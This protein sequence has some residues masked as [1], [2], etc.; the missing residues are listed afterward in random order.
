MPAKLLNQLTKGTSMSKISCRD[1]PIDVIKQTYQQVVFSGRLLGGGKDY[2]ERSRSC[3]KEMHRVSSSAA[4]GTLSTVDTLS[5]LAAWFLFPLAHDAESCGYPDSRVSTRKQHKK[6]RSKEEGLLSQLSPYLSTCKEKPHR[7]ISKKDRKSCSNKVARKTK[8]RDDSESSNS[9]FLPPAMIIGPSTPSCNDDDSNSDLSVSSLGEACYTA[10]QMTKCSK[11]DE[12]L[13]PELPAAA[14]LDPNSLSP[15][16]LDYV[17]T[18]MDVARMARNAAR[19]LDVQSILGLP[20]ITYQGGPPITKRPS[21]ASRSGGWSWTIVEET[22]G[23]KESSR[24]MEET[25]KDSHDAEV[26]VICLEHFVPGDRLRV[27]PCDHSF[28]SIHANLQYVRII[29]IEMILS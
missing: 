26:C 28:V 29:T 4:E 6:R 9:D 5:S 12:N 1:E 15:H 22:E 19:H 24:T 18:Q 27:L 17:I 11:D 20:V 2:L 23:Q 7:S 8:E 21:P 16:R 14:A 3:R 25:I 13:T 10:H